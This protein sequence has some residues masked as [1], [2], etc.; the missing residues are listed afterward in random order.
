MTVTDNGASDIGDALSAET[1]FTIMVMNFNDAPFSML[2]RLF[3][4]S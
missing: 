1:T 3:C 2:Q 4:P